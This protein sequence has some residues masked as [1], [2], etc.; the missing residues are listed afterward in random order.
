M[1]RSK[2]IIQ[3]SIIGIL[4]NAVLVAAKMMIGMIAGSI[5]IILDAVNNLGD[6]IS[7]IVTI[8]GTKL[9]AKK[10]DKKHPFGHG[11]VEYLTSVIMAAIILTAGVTSIKESIEKIIHPSDAEFTTVTLIIIAIG[12]AVKLVIGLYTKS[13]GKKIN[14]NTL[15]ASGADALF[16]AIISAGTFVA[17]LITMIWGINLDGYIGA[18]ISCFIIKAGIEMLLETLNAIIGERAD[19]EL[20]KT[21]KKKITELPGINGAYDLILHNYG[22]ND[23]I[24]SVHV[25]VNDNLNAHEIHKLIHS[26]SKMVYHEF[27]IIMTV[28]IYATNEIDPEEAEMKAKMLEIVKKYEDVIGA[29]GFFVDDKDMLITFDLVMNFKADIPKVLELVAKEM[30]SCY[31]NYTVHP[32]VDYDFS[33]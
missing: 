16:D 17:A 19:A 25:E 3:T 5:A 12:V 8:V 24:G 31:P 2:K 21:I 29:H 10:P 11:R 15:V 6:A 23:N 4:V 33:D 32:N 1:E 14:A 28:S 22:P 7:S 18:I 13:V 26:V 20:T 9:A 30:H 27:G